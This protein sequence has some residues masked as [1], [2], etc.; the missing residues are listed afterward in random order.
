MYEYMRALHTK[1]FR[2]PEYAE[3]R[4]QIRQQHGELSAQMDTE[5][6][7]KL[8]RLVDALEELSDKISFTGFVAG[9]RLASGLAKELAQEAPYSFVAD[10]EQFARTMLQRKE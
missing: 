4:E 2:E 8:L 9:F 6:R 7:K 5:T 1:F 10:Q 3:L